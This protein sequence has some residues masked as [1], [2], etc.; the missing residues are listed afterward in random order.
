VS[1][2]Q[3][4]NAPEHAINTPVPAEPPVDLPTSPEG[5]SADALMVA[6]IADDFRGADILLLDMRKITPIVDFFVI[7]TATSK[8]QMKSLAE[9]VDVVMKKRGSARRGAEG[10]G[11]SVWML[12]DYG[13]VVLHVFTPE[14]RELYALENLWADAPKLDWRE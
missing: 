1:E 10:E 6:R 2:T 11:E 3:P 8:R 9:E 4:D 12:R 7:A 13:H 5:E 14:G